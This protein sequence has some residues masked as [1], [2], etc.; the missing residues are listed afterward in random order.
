MEV[1]SAGDGTTSGSVESWPFGR[2]PL[3]PDVELAPWTAE[4]LG[5]LCRGE[6]E[7]D[8]Y[9][10]F[11]GW[12]SR[13]R[14]ALDLALA[15]GLAV[16][17]HGDRLAAL[18][19]HLDDYAREVLDVSE[20]TAHDLA[21]LGCGLRTRPL[22]REALRSGRVQLRSAQTVFPVARGEAEGEWV[23]RAAELTVRELEDEVRRAGAD[24]GDADEP[25]LRLGALLG[26][27]ERVLVD[28]G[29]D[30]VREQ[31]PG[32]SRVEALEGMAQELLGASTSDPDEDERRPLGGDFRPVGGGERGVQARRVAL[33]AETERWA[34]V[35]GLG[36]VPAPDVRFH[37][38]DSAQEVDRRLRAVARV[39]SRWEELLGH[40]AYAIQR[41]GLHLRLGF[42]DF[43]HYVQERLR[44]PARAVEQRVWLEKRLVASPALQEARRQK[45]AYEKLRLLARLPEAEIGSWTPR[46]LALTCIALRRRLE[47]EKERQMRAARRLEAPL[48]RR[49]AVLVGAAL[50]VVRD[51]FGQ[52]LSAG[53][54]LALMAWHFIE[55]WK[56]LAKPRRTRSWKVRERDGGRCQVPGCSHHATH[57]HHIDFRSHGGGDE[58]ANQ[59]SVCAFHHL[60]CIHGGYLRVVG[61]APDQLTWF[62]GGEP[63]R[64]GP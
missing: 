47:G 57:A 35:P 28:A 30:L 61:R 56:D 29:L 25:W 48:P 13:A 21:R 41:A 20:R 26:P 37:E 53:K 50:Q 27:E 59:I 5:R 3:L 36:E 44:L 38:T 10:R 49:I 18:G 15:E 16:L 6:A 1:T 40:C 34:A 2:A 33:E 45:L 32:V 63:W 60:R 62:L 46:A 31:L 64:G 8:L 54:C 24:P 39:R 58:E 55:T 42:A 14:G 19:Y 51:R 12:A 22:L 17:R 43:R 52:A 9:E 7:A 11:L 4:E 23:A